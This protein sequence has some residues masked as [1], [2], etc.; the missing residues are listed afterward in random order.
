MLRPIPQ[1]R[2]EKQKPSDQIQNRR[3]VTASKVLTIF[4]VE[5]PGIIPAKEKHDTVDH[6]QK[7]V[8][9]AIKK[10][11]SFLRK[12]SK[13]TSRELGETVDEMQK[14]I[15]FLQKRRAKLLREESKRKK[16]GNPK[17]DLKKDQ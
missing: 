17:K 4:G 7:S 6:E 12:P 11:M 8:S 3:K 16:T 9:T 1:E 10:L 13:M 2:L 15:H 5:I 14:S